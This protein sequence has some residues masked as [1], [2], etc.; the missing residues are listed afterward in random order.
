MASSIGASARPTTIEA[1]IMMPAVASSR[2]TSQAPIASTADCS[3][4]RAIFEVLPSRPPTL[5]TRVCAPRN[6]SLITPQRRAI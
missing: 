2:T 6:S 5:L 1:A 4:M 3:I